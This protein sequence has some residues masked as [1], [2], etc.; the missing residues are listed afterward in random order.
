MNPK[1]HLGYL[2]LFCASLLLGSPANAGFF[3]IDDVSANLT[4]PRD[5]FGVWW[6]QL[7][8]NKP[9]VSQEGFMPTLAVTLK[10][11]D[12]IAGKDTYVKGYFFSEDGKLVHGFNTPSL[13]GVNTGHLS[14]SVMQAVP[15]MIK[16][17]Q[18]S[19]VGFQVPLQLLGSSWHAV[20]VFGDKDEA[21]A[22]TYP[23][24]LSESSFNYPEKK[25]VED[26]SIKNIKRKKAIDPVVEYV[27]KAGAVNGKS[28]QMTLFLRMPNGISDPS[29]VKG[30]MVLSMIWYGIDVARRD[31]QQPELRGDYRGLFRYANEH[32][33]AIL[34]WGGPAKHWDAGKNYDA[35]T[36]QAERSLDENLDNVADVWEK[37]VQEISEKYGLPKKDYL[38]WGVCRAAQWAHRLCLRKPDYFLATYLLIPGSFDKPTPEGSKVLWC[39]CTGERYGG[40]DNSLRWYKECRAMGYPIIYKAYE[41]LGHGTSGVSLGF[42][43]K[44]FDFALTQKDQRDQYDA[45]RQSRISSFQYTNSG[46]ALIPWSPAFQNPPFYGDII[47]QE[48]YPVA[49]ADMIPEGLRTSLPTK[50]LADYWINGR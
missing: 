31:M 37:G 30:V 43:F 28:P 7:S 6:D 20:V 4:P 33:L 45:M 22:M 11:E 5:R 35:M 39:L 2:L 14:H 44:F 48:M 41:G 49:Q 38:L 46:R 23:Q 10:T 12:D 50:E 24:T 15:S 19:R 36:E 1:S 27:V 29:D 8:T 26:H 3:K 34:A 17:D 47:N 42:A 9:Q 16:K 21:V 40:Y 13:A 18:A 25:L 32:K